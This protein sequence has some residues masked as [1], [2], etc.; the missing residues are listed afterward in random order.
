MTRHVKL[1]ARRPQLGWKVRWS[2]WL[3]YVALWSTALLTPHP[4][5]AAQ[6]LIP[7][8]YIFLSAKL[9]HFTAYA[10]LAVLSVWL[11]VPARFRGPLYAL[12]F[13]HGAATELLQ[14]FVPLRHPAVRDVAIDSLGLLAGLALSWGLYLARR[15]REPLRRPANLPCSPVELSR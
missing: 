10:V 7:A 15:D 3:A 9:L 13:A 1:L 6:A 4:I 8:D 2:V 14:T 12:L 11:R 5:R